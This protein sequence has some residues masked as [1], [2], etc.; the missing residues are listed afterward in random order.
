MLNLQRDEFSG[1]RQIGFRTALIPERLAGAL[2]RDC[3]V[4]YDNSK[5]YGKGK[6]K[7]PVG[8]AR[9]LIDLAVM[10]PYVVSGGNYRSKNQ[11]PPDQKGRHL[12][13]NIWTDGKRVCSEDALQRE[14]KTTDVLS[15][16][17]HVRGVAKEFLRPVEGLDELPEVIYC[18]I[19]CQELYPDDTTVASYLHHDAAPREF[20][21][22]E[23]IKKWTTKQIPYPYQPEGVAL[24]MATADLI[25]FCNEIVLPSAYTALQMETNRRRRDALQGHIDE[26]EL[27]FQALAELA[28]AA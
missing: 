14:I 15:K 27:Y 3:L 22:L 25:P 12:H 5:H 8:S 18:C 23:E 10:Q 28:Q 11:L 20:H 26:A 21:P 24:G 17:L 2:S 13:G 19:H 4:A 16:Q 9:A 7:F 6:D 1:R